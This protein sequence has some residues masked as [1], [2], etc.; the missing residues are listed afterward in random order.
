[1]ERPLGLLGPSPCEIK[2]LAKRDG[3][4]IDEVDYAAGSGQ[5]EDGRAVHR[6]S[7]TGM[8]AYCRTS[9]PSFSKWGRDWYNSSESVPRRFQL[10]PGQV[11]CDAMQ[12]WLWKSWRPDNSFQ[13]TRSHN[14]FQAVIGDG[15][16]S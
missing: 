8:V 13:L 11:D 4:V 7:R 2:K 1:M 9:N 10:K 3:L 16:V 12:T 14:D 5:M 15:S 6:H